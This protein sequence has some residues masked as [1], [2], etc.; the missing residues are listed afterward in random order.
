MISSAGDAQPMDRHLV[1]G[2]A[3]FSKRPTSAPVLLRSVHPGS[4]RCGRPLS[5]A[6]SRNALGQG[7]PMPVQA[8]PGVSNRH[9]RITMASE[10]PAL[11]AA[12]GNQLQGP[13]RNMTRKEPAAPPA[14]ENVRKL[15]G[16]GQEGQSALS[17][18]DS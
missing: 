13:A 7:I 16:F 1:T 6:L 4:P 2:S 17:P 5:P 8:S 11:Q 12:S 14:H 15:S 3:A 9:N 18:A 10:K